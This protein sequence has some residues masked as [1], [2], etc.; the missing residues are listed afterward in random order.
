MS[1]SPERIIPRQFTIG[2]LFTI[3]TFC[4]LG[5]AA[6][7]NANSWWWCLVYT[8][9]FFSVIVSCVTAIFARGALRAF[10]VGVVLTSVLYAYHFVAPFLLSDR[11]LLFIR[12]EYWSTQPALDDYQQHFQMIW[13]TLWGGPISFFGGSMAWLVYRQRFRVPR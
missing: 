3:T 8:M 5:F 11:L 1:M 13:H 9:S 2:G 4:G 10:A 6:L 7:G 12:M